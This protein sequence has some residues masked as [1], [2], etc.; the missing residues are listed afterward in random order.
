[1][2]IRGKPQSPWQNALS[3]LAV[4]FPF[5]VEQDKLVLVR[6]WER[7]LKLLLQNGVRTSVYCRGPQKRARAQRL[8]SDS[9]ETDDAKEDKERKSVEVV[10]ETALTPTE[11]FQK[12][13]EKCPDMLSGLLRLLEA[14]GSP[15]AENEKRSV[16]TPVVP[17]SSKTDPPKQRYKN[18]IKKFFRAEKT[19]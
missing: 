11:V 12:T 5:V 4:E 2:G 17:Q 7:I 6:R 3:Y 18:R 14:K 9:A 16:Q 8:E 1:L 15:P 10:I 19:S 13:F